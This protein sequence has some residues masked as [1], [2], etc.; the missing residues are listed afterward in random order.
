MNVLFT[1]DA[2]VV[3]AFTGLAEW[4]GFDTAAFISKTLVHN[5]EPDRELVPMRGRLIEALE[6]KLRSLALPASDRRLSVIFNGYQYEEDDPESEYLHATGVLWRI[7]NFE[8]GSTA[9]TAARDSFEIEEIEPR[10]ADTSSPYAFLA[11]GTT[12]GLLSPEVERLEQL[13]HER[14]P[15]KALATKAL[16]IGI[17]ASRSPK[18]GSAIGTS[19]SAAVL[20]VEPTAPIWIQY[21]A[22]S[23][24]IKHFNPNLI[25]ASAGDQPV[26]ALN[27]M[28]VET[29]SPVA[30]GFPGT[31]R[32]APCP[33][34]S[35]RKYKHC[36]GDASK[37]RGGAYYNRLLV[38]D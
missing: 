10:K 23:P 22:D 26:I 31:P 12:A 8:R 19:W 34:L 5:A 38:E 16:E 21:Y 37:N 6:K 11:A 33:C 15:A 29:V 27:D 24:R 4:G 9:A 14:R 18:S 30:H 7:S 20:P 32:N 2:K 17:D 36:H 35:G 1:A 28:M 25:D 13:L 3:I